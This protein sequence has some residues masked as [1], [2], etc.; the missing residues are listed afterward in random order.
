MFD[1]TF[2]NRVG[3]NKSLI[4]YGVYNTGD[5]YDEET[6][7]TNLWLNR[8]ERLD[9]PLEHLKLNDK[10]ITGTLKKELE[11][12]TLNMPEDLIDNII[13]NIQ[14]IFSLDQNNTAPSS[15]NV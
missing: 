11:Y 13:Y 15:T 1:I 3:Y 5:I 9:I 6:V 12:S 8:E 4:V 14:D 10:I 2:E 7:D